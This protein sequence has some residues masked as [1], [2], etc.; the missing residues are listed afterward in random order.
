MC[1]NCF[2]VLLVCFR[3]NGLDYWCSHLSVDCFQLCSLRFSMAWRWLERRCLSWVLWYVLSMTTSHSITP[4]FWIWSSVAIALIQIG[5]SCDHVPLLVA[6]RPFHGHFPW[7]AHTLE[8]IFSLTMVTCLPYAGHLCYVRSSRQPFEFARH[9]REKYNI[10]KLTSLGKNTT[11][12]SMNI[13]QA[14]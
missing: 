14:E 4:W 9:T 3:C 7:S 5:L 12:N 11:Q 6:L 8:V 2:G 10:R 1:Y 13:K